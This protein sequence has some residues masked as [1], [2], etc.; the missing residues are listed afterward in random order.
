[1]KLKNYTSLGLLLILVFGCNNDCTIKR[2]ELLSRDYFI[3]SNEFRG[4]TLLS[5]IHEDR[6]KSFRSVQ[7]IDEN[8][9]RTNNYDS[10]FQ[11]VSSRIYTFTANALI[12]NAIIYHNTEF[13][14]S[15]IIEGT[16]H[17]LMD[18]EETNL[19]YTIK[20]SDVFV[21]NNIVYKMNGKGN[22]FKFNGKDRKWVRYDFKRVITLT[23][24]IRSSKREYIGYLIFAHGIGL[25]ENTYKY[26]VDSV[27][28]KIKRKVLLNIGDK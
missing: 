18:N 14:S 17:S 16:S 27:H 20:A 13:L 6:S 15:E 28:Y 5:Y 4:D 3:L 7:M 24:S 26:K 23:D 10:T 2:E 1:M 9:F 12:L 19:H 8:S 11:P 21:D 22:D 25:V